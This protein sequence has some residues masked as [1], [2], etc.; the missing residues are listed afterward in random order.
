MF[1]ERGVTEKD[2]RIA[3]VWLD[4]KERNLPIWTQLSDEQRRLV[5]IRL[6]WAMT[7][8]LEEDRT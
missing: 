3:R 6:L 8:T 2:L 5:N 1:E 4:A 7:A